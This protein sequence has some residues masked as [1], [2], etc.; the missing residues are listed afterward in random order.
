[1]NNGFSVEMKDFKSPK[2]IRFGYDSFQSV[3]GLLNELNVSKV[4]IISDKGD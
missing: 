1:M 3:K 2:C 4:L